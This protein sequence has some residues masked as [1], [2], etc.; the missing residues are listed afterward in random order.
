MAN[1]EIAPEIAKLADLL[2]LRKVAL[3]SGGGADGSGVAFNTT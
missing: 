3:S 1:G 2:N